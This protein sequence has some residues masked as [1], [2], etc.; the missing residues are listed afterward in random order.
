MKN[1]KLLISG[2][3]A[4]AMVVVVGSGFAVW[5]FETGDESAKG[6]YNFGLYVTPNVET[7]GTVSTN[8]DYALILDQ[9][10][11]PNLEDGKT[12]ADNPDYYKRGI[13]V[14]E[15][16]KNPNY[17]AKET[18]DPSKMNEYVTLPNGSYAYDQ[19]SEL[20]GFWIQEQTDAQSIVAENVN[21][22]F[23]ETKIKLKKDNLAKYVQVRLDDGLYKASLDEDDLKEYVT[24]KYNWGNLSSVLKGGVDSDY[25][26]TK[27]KGE[28]YTEISAMPDS[29]VEGSKVKT[30]L[31][32]HDDDNV[33]A[34]WKD[35]DE[36]ISE[37]D[38]SSLVS[39]DLN[40][41]LTEDDFY[42]RTSGSEEDGG[43]GLSLR[44]H[45]A[46]KAYVVYNDT[47]GAVAQICANQEDADKALK[48]TS[49]SSGSLESQGYK[50]SIGYF[51]YYK[52]G[53]SSEED[54]K[55]ISYFSNEKNDVAT[56]E[57]DAADSLIIGT[58]SFEVKE[59]YYFRYTLNTTNYGST[60][61]SENTMLYENARFCYFPYTKADLTYTTDDDNR[62]DHIQNTWYKTVID[63]ANLANNLKDGVLLNTT[64]DVSFIAKPTDSTSLKAMIST[65]NVSAAGAA[66]S[67]AT[68]ANIEQ[69]VDLS[70]Q[71][72]IVEFGSEMRTAG[73]ASHISD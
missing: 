66:E 47:T 63:E 3:A 29:S 21:D 40:E 52:A 45:K 35:N 71:Y 15:L 38:I 64:D 59:C 68:S 30:W 60:G 2:L 31:D 12:L 37:G 33:D 11:L 72:V 23:F 6:M 49:E 39:G 61:I 57:V 50:S 58:K 28:I 13:Y 43:M 42:L 26:I 54:L 73:T 56:E 5:N 16:K 18:S 27:T 8:N 51:M 22:M 65:F 48:P 36:I 25:R 32:A 34:K 69:K 24:Y 46:L 14:G 7:I 67:S 44:S 70:Q 17:D 20:S 1:K 19:V 41:I 55:D 4:M 53:L 62:K 9:G 10:G